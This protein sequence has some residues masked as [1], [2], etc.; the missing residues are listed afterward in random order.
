M[1]SDMRGQIQACSEI[2]ERRLSRMPSWMEH[3]LHCE[4]DDLGVD[5]GGAVPQPI[6][7]RLIEDL[8]LQERH[9]GHFVAFWDRRESQGDSVRLYRE[10]EFV[11]PTL[12]QLDLRL[13]TLPKH[14]SNRLAIQFVEPLANI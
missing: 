7:D 14:L 2:I 12:E 10:I 11:E 4:L 1:P 13:H 3:A 6:L 8:I 9:Q 5:Y